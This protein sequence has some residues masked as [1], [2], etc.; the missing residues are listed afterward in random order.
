MAFQ[1]KSGGL[2]SKGNTGTQQTSL[3][4]TS[5]DTANDIKIKS[6]E[7]PEKKE[8]DCEITS[9]SKRVFENFT[10]ECDLDT[11]KVE[12]NSSLS[13]RQ[14]LSDDKD[15][16][17]EAAQEL[18]DKPKAT[19]SKDDDDNDLF[20]AHNKYQIHYSYIN[21]LKENKRCN[22]FA[23]VK[24][25]VKPPTLTKTK[26]MQEILILV[27]PSC[28]KKDSLMNDVLLHI[29]YKHDPNTKSGGFK[30]GEILRLY[31]IHPEFFSPNNC[32]HTKVYSLNAIVK[33]SSGLHD[34]IIPD[35]SSKDYML[36]DDDKEII[37]SLR[38]W[39]HKVNNYQIQKTINI[40][41]QESTK[42]MKSVLPA[43]MK[44]TETRSLK[45]IRETVCL[46]TRL[47]EI[48]RPGAYV[49]NGIVLNIKKISLE[50][51]N[52]NPQ[53]YLLNVSDGTRANF[54]TS[55]IDMNNL[56]QDL[57]QSER[58]QSR[59]IDITIMYIP[60]DQKVPHLDFEVGDVIRM[61][62]VR[63]VDIAVGIPEYRGIPCM[64]FKMD[65]KGLNIIKVLPKDCSISHGI[66]DN[67]KTILNHKINDVKEMDSIMQVALKN[68][69]KVEN[70]QDE[71]KRSTI[72]AKFNETIDFSSEEIENNQ[73]KLK[74]AS[75]ITKLNETINFFSG[76]L[77]A[78]TQCNDGVQTLLDNKTGNKE[79]ENQNEINSDPITPYQK[80]KSEIEELDDSV[81]SIEKLINETC[82]DNLF[83]TRGK[84]KLIFSLSESCCECDT[85]PCVH[86]YV[87]GFCSKCKYYASSDELRRSFSKE[88]LLSSERLRCFNCSKSNSKK[89]NL[90]KK[91]L[92]IF[93]CRILIKDPNENHKIYA[94][95]SG[96]DAELFFGLKP[97]FKFMINGSERLQKV[98]R[99]TYNLKGDFCI[100]KKLKDDDKYTYSIKNTKVH[101]CINCKKF[102]TCT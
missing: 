42:N 54:L 95:V 78:S 74:N 41:E 43:K 101:A 22:I 69:K 55:V 9:P 83:L 67:L 27:D 47:C 44:K 25:V 102:S 52:G 92:P 20:S 7:I 17:K 36:T 3:P 21:D 93:R 88:E 48:T 23:I 70:K 4:E 96:S 34:E 45:G 85:D 82:D 99:N 31:K 28:T 73:E 51:S 91:L 76:E 94:S 87:W 89:K 79:E 29:F 26:N 15:E 30:R 61:E 58:V 19:T 90:V 60:I 50:G 86:N 35:T 32:L 46:E 64:E 81:I 24:D 77:V 40:D 16:K 8:T 71:L 62:Y 38:N 56:S 63:C 72:L 75:L 98:V 2:P 33:F 97:E 57:I 14:K 80:A 100:L 49:M 10:E 53:I 11:T 84:L 1:P 66:K 68:L 59:S 37:L 13:K 39:W 6:S 5:K 18:F 12:E 65:V